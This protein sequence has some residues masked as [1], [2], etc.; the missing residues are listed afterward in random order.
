[1]G[2]AVLGCL[3]SW[4]VLAKR[5]RAMTHKMQVSTMPEFFEARYAD[6]GLKI[7]SAIVIFI[8]LA[9]YTAS[10]YM[11]LSYLFESV[12]H[13]P[14]IYCMLIMAVLTA[15]YLVLGG[16]MATVW[17][18]FIQGIIMIVG[19]VLMVY[20][21]MKNDV[22]GGLMNGIRR[23]GEIPQDGA[24]LT[25]WF[26]GENW[27][28]LLSLIF[29][30]SIGTWGL[31]QMIHKFYTI[32]DDRSVK[33]AAVISTVFALLIGCSA[34]FA[35]AFGRL[36][37][38]N[39]LPEGGYDAIMPALLNSALP[40][41]MMGVIIVLILSASMSTLSALVIT[42]SSSIS[43]DLV[44]GHFA[45]GMSDKDTV[46]LMRVLCVIFV[47]ISFII[48][49][50]KPKEIITLMSFSWGT[51]AGTFLGPYLWG[52]YSKKITR[53]GAWSGMIAG[54]S[55]SIIPA[56]V[57]GFDQSLAPVFGMCAMIVSLIVTPVVSYYTPKYEEK[58]IYYSLR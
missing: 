43:I 58:F 24:V 34:Y 38:N 42:S 12:F 50:F 57:S 16:Y 3:L 41:V 18:D 19:V 56:V 46:G 9:P 13:I 55:A 5:T 23:L 20:F 11:G 28:S 40:E 49:A 7:F 30:T 54:F 25:S 48:A 36:F 45:P 17:T 4:L 1:M 29:L 8:F 26:G 2:N 22:V 14:Y 52:L 27:F 15:F 21:I 44:K 53:I 39:Q 33:E 32:K 51:V 37:L 10:V 6:K 47:G 31:P 35:G